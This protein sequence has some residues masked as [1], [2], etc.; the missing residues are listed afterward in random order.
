[1][2]KV[3]ETFTVGTDNPHRP[4]TL[5]LSRG[6][7]TEQL[8]SHPVA[9]DLANLRANLPFVS[10]VPFPKASFL[11]S[12]AVN[13]SGDVVIPDNAVLVKLSGQAS[14]LFTEKGSADGK[15]SALAQAQG[16]PATAVDVL[17]SG[18][19]EWL[20]CAG[21][22]TISVR[23]PNATTQLIGGRFIFRDEI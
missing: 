9:D 11:L 14:F 6:A 16:N 7:S 18:E 15:T 13:T 20:Y 19:T 12:L 5:D 1:M 8:D 4:E 2:E 10:I 22:K 23:N 17:A 3:P 21:L